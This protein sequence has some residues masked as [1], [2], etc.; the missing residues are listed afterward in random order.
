[1]AEN[2]AGIFRQAVKQPFIQNRHGFRRQTRESST[3]RN[4]SAYFQS[5]WILV[6]QSKLSLLFPLDI[7]GSTDTILLSLLSS[8]ILVI[9]LNNQEQ[10]EIA[11]LSGA[12][13]GCLE[14]LLIEVTN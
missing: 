5:E 3:Y 7:A 14:K 1:M 2:V 10:E 4:R 9:L 11:S 8:V 13:E 6:T 12:V